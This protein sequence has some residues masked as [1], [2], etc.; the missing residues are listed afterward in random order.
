M[1]LTVPK[2]IFAL[3]EKFTSAYASMALSVYDA[4][5]RIYCTLA[6]DDADG[7]LDRL[8]QAGAFSGGDFTRHELG[9]Y[10]CL[11]KQEQ[12]SQK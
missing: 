6:Q 3:T 8:Y 7:A 5:G 4:G 10:A 1:V 2:N 11:V 9:G 12:L